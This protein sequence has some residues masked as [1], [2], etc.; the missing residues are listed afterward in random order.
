VVSKS[1]RLAKD[2]SPHLARQGDNIMKRKN[3]CM[4]KCPIARTLDVIGDWWSLLILSDAF[5]GKRRFGEFQ[6]SLGLAKNILCARLRKLVAHGVL[7]AVPASDGSAYQEY[8]LSEKGRGLYIVLV[9]LRQWGESCLF[10][11][12]EPDLLLVDRKSGQPV[13]PLELRSQDG[14]VLGPEDLELVNTQDR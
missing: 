9:A 1:N 2:F 8:V 5:F 12:G 6:K 4:E 11:K 13:R 14:R 3:L 10:E 7:Q